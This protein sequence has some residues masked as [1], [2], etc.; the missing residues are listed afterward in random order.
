MTAAIYLVLTLLAGFAIVQRLWPHPP[1]LVRLVGAFAVGV[2]VTGWVAFGAAWAAHGFGADDATIAGVWVACGANL[3]IIAL[4]RAEFRRSAVEVPGS[5]VAGVAGALGLSAWIM[6]ARLSGSPLSVSANTWGDTA[7]HIGIARSFSQGQNFPP[8]LPI[9]S[10]ETIRYHFGFDFY[11]G[12]LERAG[13]PIGWAFNLPGALAFTAIL[14]LLVEYGRFLWRS[15]SVGVVAAVLFATDS[16]MAW[17]RYLDKEGSLGAA[18][19]PSTLWHHVGYD[20]GGPYNGDKI[21]IFMTL[22]PYL[23]QT[24]LLVALVV[25]LFVGYVLLTSLRGPGRAEWVAPSGRA[26][27][28]GPVRLGPSATVGLGLL[29]GAS[30]WL[31]GI[32]VLV[33]MTCCAVLFY[34]FGGRVRSTAQPIVLVLAAAIPVFSIGAD[35]NNDA[36][37]YLGFLGVLAAVTLATPLRRSMPFLIA[38]AA[39]ALPQLVWLNGGIETGGSASF[40]TGYLVGDFNAASPH[41]WWDFATY[42]WLNLGLMLP[43]LVLAAIWCRKA[44][45]KLLIGVMSIFVIGNLV[46]FGRELGGHNHKVFNLWEILANL[47]AAYALVRLVTWMWAELPRLHRAVRP[48]IARSAAVAAAGV[49]AAL[50]LASGVLD[51]LTLKNDPRY[52]VFGDRAPAMAWIETHTKPDAVFLTAYGE[53][54]TLPTLAGRRVYLGGFEP[55][56]VIMGYDSKPREAR[57]A[58]IYAAPDKA[59]ACNELQ[60]TG[61]DYIQYGYPERDTTQYRPNPSLFPGDFAPVY[62]DRD[63]TFYDVAASCGGQTATARA[64]TRGVTSAPSPPTPTP[65][66]A[67]AADVVFQHHP[68][69]AIAPLA[70]LLLALVAGTGGYLVRAPKQPRTAA[71][72]V[73]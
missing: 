25:V 70:A 42:W 61:V 6:H 71:I 33:M 67:T 31:N 30:F 28:R 21:S 72:D 36:L 35:R 68:S 62:S 34:V 2:V 41:S 26:E 51:Y 22:N 39:F 57:I 17:L 9:F 20:G 16:S 73:R 8:E 15:T 11:A 7:L 18:L 63:F 23:T 48:V 66:P 37:R 49:A 54:Y 59:A 32:V 45:R 1:V 10:G 43:L 38:A 14:V 52:Q 47:F 5:D 50:L 27:P 69:R 12:S 46:A 19:K 29:L 13:L 60:G 58:Q 56:T 53:V 55:W 3:A 4:L 64:A 24:H 65:I 40:H 44:D